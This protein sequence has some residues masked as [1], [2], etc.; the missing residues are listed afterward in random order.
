MALLASIVLPGGASPA[1]ATDTST[2]PAARAVMAP[3]SNG[4]LAIAP[5]I[6]VDRELPAASVS[7]LLNIVEKARVR[8]AYF[9]GE[10][11]SRPDILFCSTIECYRKFGGIGLGYTRGNQVLISPC[12]SRAAIV[13]HEL[14]HVELAARLGWQAEILDKVPQ[15][16]DEGTAVMVSLAY[17]FSDEAW[18]EASHDGESAP[19]LN[20]LESSKDWNQVTGNDGANMQLSYGTARQEVVRWYAKVGRNG[21]AQLIQALKEKRHFHEAYQGIENATGTLLAVK[22]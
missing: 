9:Y 22:N 17:E 21:L 14:S 15:W 3:A 4:M 6:Y 18:C 1:H 20:E 13:S 8:T 19:Q 7:R 5:H 16:F 12:G 11:I 2:L 10:L